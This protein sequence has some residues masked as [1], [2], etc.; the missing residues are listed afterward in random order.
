MAQDACLALVGTVSAG[1]ALPSWALGPTACMTNIGASCLGV[2]LAPACAM[3]GPYAHSLPGRVPQITSR[4]LH[5]S[6]SIMGVR[7]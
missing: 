7:S 2:H 4:P 3:S 6:R 5:S 1:R